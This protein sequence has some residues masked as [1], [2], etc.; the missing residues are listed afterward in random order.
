GRGAS[1]SLA[2]LPLDDDPGVIRHYLW[3][4]TDSAY[5][6]SLDAIAR[7]RSVLRSVTVSAE[8][9]DFAPSK[10]NNILK[11]RPLTKFDDKT[12]ADRT[13]RISAIFNTYTNLRA[14]V[15]DYSAI[16]SFHRYVHSEGT[17]VR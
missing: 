3:L 16:E 7:K 2:G 4:Q 12:W 1:Y 14:S 17:I 15:A 13:K 5:K 11:D 9:P 8:L 10:P 6:A